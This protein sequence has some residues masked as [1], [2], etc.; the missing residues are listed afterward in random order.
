[1]QGVQFGQNGAF[2]RVQ[3]RDRVAPEAVGGGGG[4]AAPDEQVAP[5][6][7]AVLK[8]AGLLRH[9]HRQRHLQ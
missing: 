1:M 7:V 6:Q 3:T 5:V 8:L 2:H 4:R 9:T